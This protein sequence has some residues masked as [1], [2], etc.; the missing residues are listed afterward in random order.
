[1]GFKGDLMS[2]TQTRTIFAYFLFTILFTIFFALLSACGGG[3]NDKNGSG[4]GSSDPDN[5]VEEPVEEP[6]PSVQFR[7]TWR[8]LADGETITLPL[9]DDAMY[10]YNF[11]VDWGDGSPISEITAH[12]DEDKTHTYESKGDY[13]LVIEG[14]LEAWSFNDTGDKDKILS[15][16]NFGDL[17]YKNLSGAFYGCVNL[18]VFEGGVTSDVT[19]MTS[20]FEGATQANPDVSN[21]DVSKVTDMS[22]MFEGA[23]QANPDVSNWD[24][25]KVTDMSSMFEGAT[26]AD[27]DVSGWIVSSVTG[28]GT[29]TGMTNMFNSSGLSTA[30]YDAF[31]INLADNNASVENVTLGAT[32]IQYS[33]Y[34]AKIAQDTLEDDR[35]WTITDGGDATSP[36]LST[37]R[38]PA[39]SK[40]ITLPLVSGYNY[41][42]TV[43]WGDG[44]PISEITAHDD[45]DKT[46][47]YA[48]AADYNLVIDGLLEAWSFNDTGDKDKIL[49]VED[50]GDLGYKNLSG[51]FH[52]CS[53]LAA[54]EGGITSDVTDMSS[55]FEGATSANPDVSNWNV[56]SVTDMRAMFSG[57]TNANPDVSDWD[58]SAVTDM[59]FMFYQATSADPDVSDWDVSAVTDMSFMFYQATSA[60]PDVSDWNVSVVTDMSNMFRNA[61]SADPDVSDW[62]VSEVTNMMYMFSGATSANPDVSSWDVSAVLGMHYMFDNS[63]LSTANYDALLINLADNNATVENVVLGASTTKYSSDDAKTARD[64]LEDR[65]WTITDG[66][67]YAALFRSTWKVSADG[68]TIT[69]PLVDDAMYTYNF[70]V[71]WGDGSPISE[72]TAHDD[73]D[74]VHTYAAAG[75]YNLVIEGTLE[76]WSF[77]DTGDKDKILSVE[78]F[79]DLG[80]K[81]L[82]GAFYGCVNLGVFEGGVTSDVTDMTSMFEGATQANPDVSGWDVSSV[83]DMANM[84][85]GATA[86]DPDVSGWVVSEVTDMTN[87]FNASGLSTANYNA[88]LI[89]LADNN[90]SVENVTLGVGAIQYDSFAARTALDALVDD[91][92]WTITDGGP[93]DSIASF[94]STWRV[95][96]DGETITLPLV[97][98][99]RYTYNF[100][101]DW[102]DDTGI[103]TITSFD[104]ADKTHTYAV[105]GDYN[106]VIKGTLEA[107]SFNN[108]GDKD[109]ILSVESFGD[110]GY[111]NLSGAFYGCRNLGVFEGGITSDVTAMGI[112]FSFA[113]NVTPNISHWNVSAVNNM[114]SMFQS[115]TSANPDVSNW[116]VS[117]VTFMG[118]MFFNATSANP[119]VSNWNV[120]AVNNM[121]SMF[122]ASGFSTANY[123]AFLINLANNNALVSNVV[124]GVS[125]VQYSS[126][127]AKTARDTLRNDRGWTIIDG[128]DATPP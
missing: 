38:V 111:K 9:V 28:T 124:L 80:Y 46:H 119:N 30:N 79:G 44:S 21:W 115:A 99:E 108:T 55:M 67:D 40:T 1:M 51:A 128:G 61:T 57:V 104:D 39:N 4:S 103:S 31:L 117:A 15:V 25:S 37:W 122:N 109:K 43:D 90:A 29:G 68:E 76:A 52:G 84:F 88:F 96:A 112:M 32:G 33:S 114:G 35:G 101:V 20:M 125:G 8:V 73:E 23:T 12:D 6:D 70:T 63:A 127:A 36:F 121:T 64:T 81:N 34:Y 69:L 100:T 89:N 65:G 14:T 60:N 71:D 77:N 54:F 48:T 118:S 45:A 102:G 49:S 98:H 83:T 123:D 85:N 59:S 42:F 78:N 113:T 11:T 18:G 56:S 86:A 82:S 41:N 16:E 24:V 17:G 87:M 66:G 97:D 106:I 3:G 93:A 95:L 105:A 92:G 7:S 91:R 107:W 27:P 22:S 72:I 5:P 126:E 75:D 74:K 47:T 94:R 19:D 120:S 10:T 53:N 110:L 58:V 2:K 62:N 13:N 116:N 26:Q 50:F